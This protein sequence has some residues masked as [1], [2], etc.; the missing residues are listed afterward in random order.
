M[1]KI[2]ALFIFSLVCSGLKA[3]ESL[4]IQSSTNGGI[5]GNLIKA[6]V[7]KDTLTLQLKITVGAETQKL[8][9]DFMDVYY[10]SLND[11]KKYYPIKDPQGQAIA[12]PKYDEENAGRFWEDL[13]PGQQRILWLKFPAPSSRTK[14]IDVF[15]PDFLPFKSIP[16]TR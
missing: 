2:I 3:Q 13:E 1:S 4:Q 11:G 9:F 8:Q 5:E 14:M 16:L 6:S 15:F 10:I 12:G 7:R